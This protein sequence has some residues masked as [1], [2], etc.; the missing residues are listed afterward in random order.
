MPLL[1][2]YNICPIGD[3]MKKF[4]QS[5]PESAYEILEEIRRTRNSPSVQELIRS[6][7]IP[8]WIKAHPRDEA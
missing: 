6:V 8:E 5:L 1:W 3:I 2:L 7:I 4:A